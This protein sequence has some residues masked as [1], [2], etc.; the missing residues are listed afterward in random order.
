MQTASKKVVN[1]WAM[2]DWANSAYSLVITSTIFPAY[3]EAIAVDDRFVSPTAVTFLGRTYENSA[4]YNYTIAIALLIGACI[5]PLLSAIA[6]L[7]GNK[8]SFMRFFLTMGSI[9]CSGLFFFERHT[10]GWGLFCMVLACIGFWASWVFYNSFLPEIAAPE[11]RD[12]ISARGFSYGYVGSVIL[13]LICFVFVFVPSIVGGDDSTTIQ[14]RICFLLVGLWWF[15]FGSYSLSKMPNSKPSDQGDLQHNIITKGYKELRMVW[16][17]LKEQHKL[18]RFLSAFFCYNMGVQTVMLVAAFYGKSE[19]QIPT[20]N[21]IGAILIIQLIA[22]PGA[23]TIAR[24]SALIGN[25]QTLMILVGFW[26]VG[27]IIG[28][29]LPVGGIYEFYGL[30]VFVGFMMGGTQ[31]LSRSTYSNLMPETHD[32]ASYFSFYDV[33]EKIATVIGLLGFGYITE[34]MGSQRSSVLALMVF[35]ILGFLL[36]VFTQ[37]EKRKTH[38]TV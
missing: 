2:Y 1:A 14:F 18:S 22:I 19:L 38:A 15:G 36:L 25:M 34:L 27:C 35:F 29:N 13:Q 37:V 21:L 28:Y 32:T 12:R 23:F 30:A 31:S 7:K 11:D 9:G 8:K 17:Q 3:F 4:L 20:P 10:L 5:S 33:T 16:H 26:C 6:D 24:L